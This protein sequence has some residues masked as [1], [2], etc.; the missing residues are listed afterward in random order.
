[1]VILGGGRTGFILAQYL[2]THRKY[3]PFVKLIER[4]KELCQELAERL[5][6]VLVV[7]AD[8]TRPDLFR[9]ENIQAADSFIAVTGQD[10]TNLLAGFLAK[11]LGVQR[12]VAELHRED[13]VPTA[14][15]MRIDVTVIPRLMVASTVLRAIPKPNVKTLSLLKEG[16][17]EVVEVVV[18]PGSSVSGKSLRQIGLP[19]E[20]V[21]GAIV[22]GDAVVVPRGD[23]VM[24]PGDH[25]LIFASPRAGPLLEFYF[26]VR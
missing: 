6:H 7:N 5:H 19:E 9:E 20:V 18:S 8:G 17:L 15:R 13:Y 1:M 3:G 11:D 16:N 21:V 24:C 22:R 25:V 14:K 26:G 10:Q 2:E 12:V 4:D 23:T